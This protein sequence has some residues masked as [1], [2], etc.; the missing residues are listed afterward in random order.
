MLV[1]T[2]ISG[3]SSGWNL[4]TDLQ[5][6]ELQLPGEV[7]SSLQFISLTEQAQ[8]SW[9]A[10]MQNERSSDVLTV[11]REGDLESLNGAILKITPEAVEFEMDGQTIQAPRAKVAGLIWFRRNAPTVTKATEFMDSNG[12]TLRLKSL[13]LG[14]DAEIKAFDLTT[15]SGIHLKV[16]IEKTLRIDYSAANLQWLDKLEVLE[17]VSLSSIVS[18]TLKEIRDKL[19]APKFIATV[20]D[21]GLA[22]PDPTRTNLVFDGPGRFVFRVPDGYTRLVT[23]VQRRGSAKVILPLVVSIKSDDKEIWNQKLD[24]EQLRLDVLAKVEPNKKCEISVICEG[25]IPFGSYTVLIH[26]HLLP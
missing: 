1:V 26:P 6:D 5:A 2:D 23:T 8:K 24:G 12:S 17:S 22:D 11:L 16:P 19:L 3:S 15:I 7:V 14:S 18:D 20:N 13:K 25:P 9:A 4:K 21:T 10:L